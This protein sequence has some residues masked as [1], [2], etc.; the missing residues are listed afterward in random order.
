[1]KEAK[2][3]MP[4]LNPLREQDSAHRIPPRKPTDYSEVLRR[5]GKR[6][7]FLSALMSMPDDSHFETQHA[8]EQVLL[9]LRQHPISNVGWIII[10]LGLVLLPGLIIPFFPFVNSLPPQYLAFAGVGWW[11]FIAAYVIEQFL[12]WYFNIYIITDERVIDVDFYSLLYKRVS[13]AKTDNIQDVSA[14]TA[15]F[16]GALFNYGD[17]TIQT[18]GERREFEFGKVPEPAMVTKFINELILEEQ[19]E[20]REGRVS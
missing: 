9:V 11:M 12:N 7:G 20:E 17:I 2:V 6:S 8:D 15:G 5:W 19:R 16:F 10:A 14:T 4:G 13:E 1:M 18:A 3:V